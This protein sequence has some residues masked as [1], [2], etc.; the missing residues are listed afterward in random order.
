MGGVRA[1]GVWLWSCGRSYVP[2]AAGACLWVC[3]LH[4]PIPCLSGRLAWWWWWWCLRIH[5]TCWDHLAQQPIRT[6]TIWLSSQSQQGSC[7]LA[8]MSHDGAERPSVCDKVILSDADS[9]ILRQNLIFIWII[10]NS[11]SQTCLL[12]SPTNL[13][14]R[15][16]FRSFG[17]VTEALGLTWS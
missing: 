5:H 4:L 3:L 1:T 6:E 15:M 7:P 10:L 2:V 13:L 17:G 12:E 14:S 8:S 16:R 9:H 11:V